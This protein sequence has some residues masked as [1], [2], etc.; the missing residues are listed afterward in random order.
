MDSE[1]L[2]VQVE[3]LILTQRPRIFAQL[4]LF[5]LFAA[6][7]TFGVFS[8]NASTKS[9]DK[10]EG[11]TVVLASVLIFLVSFIPAIYLFK[12]L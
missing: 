1:K 11:W 6:A 4:G 5:I 10:E 7:V 8:F 2:D 3:P 12:S 9:T